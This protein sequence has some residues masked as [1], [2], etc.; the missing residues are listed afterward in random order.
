M[1]DPALTCN[2]PADLPAGQVIAV[3]TV[4]IGG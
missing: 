2:D 1:S 4:F 3:S